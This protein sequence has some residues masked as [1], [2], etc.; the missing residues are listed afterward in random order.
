MTALTHGGQLAQIAQR[1]DIELPHWLDLST[2]IAPYHYP[3]GDILLSAYQQLPQTDGELLNVATDYYGHD[4]I[5]ATNGS[6]AVIKLL[7]ELWQSVLDQSSKTLTYNSSPKSCTVYLPTDGYKEHQH[8]WEQAQF[9]ICLYDEHLPDIAMLDECCVL[10]IINPNNP[11]GK[12]FSRN[13]LTRYQQALTTLNGLLVID[14]A[15]MDVITP[16]QS[17]ASLANTSNMIILRSFGKFFGLAGIRIGFVLA[18]EDWIA[19]LTNLIG[20]WQVNG[21]AQCIAKQ[22]LF[23]R[24]WQQEQRIQLAQNSNE[25]KS[26]LLRCLTPHNVKVLNQTDLFSTVTFND[27]SLAPKL[28]HALCLQAVYVRLCDDH[29]SLRFGI[30]TSAQQPKLIAALLNAITSIESSEID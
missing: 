14:E 13:E 23:D 10:V 27:H 21:P 5:L 4:S 22:A 30:A 20:P 16:C 12:L 9:S 24:Q 6:Q 28:F 18:N 15:F 7:P 11:T 29:I 8:A 3:I 1:Y 26:L 2:G 25:M 17:M 19:K